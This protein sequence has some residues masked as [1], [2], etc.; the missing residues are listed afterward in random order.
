MKSTAKIIESQE[1]NSDQISGN[2]INTK[3][4][5]SQGINQQQGYQ[6][7][8]NEINSKVIKSQEITHRAALYKGR[9]GGFLSKLTFPNEWA[10]QINFPGGAKVHYLIVCGRRRN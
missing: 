3:V 6:I 5:K 2:E 10:E 1:I 7:S 8:G 9:L 4:I